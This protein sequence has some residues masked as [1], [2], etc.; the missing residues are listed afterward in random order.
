MTLGDLQAEEDAGATGG[1]P[2]PGV[3]NGIGSRRSQQGLMGSAM[4]KD[5]T[6]DEPEEMSDG[7][8]QHWQ[9][10]ELASSWQEDLAQPQSVWYTW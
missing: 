7:R 5:N 2:P 8:W 6:W 4:V 10:N 1:T 3:L 9:L